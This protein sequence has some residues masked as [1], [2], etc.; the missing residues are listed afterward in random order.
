LTV[1]TYGHRVSGA[2]RQAV[3]RLDDADGATSR[4]LA[5]SGNNEWAAA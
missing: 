2:N 5:A 1:D 3:D 4:N